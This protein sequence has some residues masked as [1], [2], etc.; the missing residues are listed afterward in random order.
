MSAI[1]C[2]SVALKTMA[3]GTLR[4]SFDFEPSQAQD[5]FKLFASPGTPA[6]I[7]ALKQG[8]AAVAEASTPEPEMP[9]GGA[10]SKL[11][12]LWC[13][14][15]EFQKWLCDSFSV[16]IENESDASEIVRNICVVKSRAELD[17][18]EESAKK[19]QR[20]IRGPFIKHCQ[21]RGIVL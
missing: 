9:K 4:I 6:A 19:F 20:E 8:Y 15:V 10:L 11:A 18:N 13:G 17:H 7:A 12:G 16:I 5:A 21:A 1:P 2:S 3:D 14:R